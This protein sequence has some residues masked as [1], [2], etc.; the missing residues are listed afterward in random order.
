MLSTR[1][2]FLPWSKQTT[3]NEVSPT[4]TNR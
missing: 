4:P 3:G 1:Q 2:S